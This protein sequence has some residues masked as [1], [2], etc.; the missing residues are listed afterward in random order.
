MRRLNGFILLMMFAS[1][2][3]VSCSIEDEM[4]TENASEIMATDPSNQ[5][6]DPEIEDPKG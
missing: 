6:D 2:S 4:V 1:L 5:D 3:T